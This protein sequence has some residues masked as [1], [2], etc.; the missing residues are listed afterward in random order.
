[1][2]ILIEIKGYIIK[3]NI[4]LINKIIIDTASYSFFAD[5]LGIS[6]EAKGIHW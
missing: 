2:A 1:M 3:I 6:S 5:P 4:T